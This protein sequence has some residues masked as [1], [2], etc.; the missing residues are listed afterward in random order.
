MA[1]IKRFLGTFGT[2]GFGIL[3]AIIVLEI[4]GRVLH[5]APV[6][7][8]D[9]YQNVREVVGRFPEPYS[10]FWFNR[11]DGERIWVQ[12]NY[13]S[14]RDIDHD[15][16][17]DDTTTRIMF[18]GDSY[19]AGWQVP[20]ND[21]YTGRLR[22]WLSDS[23][24][25]DFINAG[26]HG[27]GTDRE[28]LYYRTEGYRYNS[29]VVVLQVYVG[30]DMIDNGIA[31]IEQRELPDGRHIATQSLTEERPYFTLGDDGELDFTAPRW[32]PS[33]RAER[34]GGIRSFLRQYVFTYALLEQLMQLRSENSDTDNEYAV[35]FDE[36]FPADYYAFAPQSKTDD[37]WQSAWEITTQLIQQLRV[38]V[39]ANGSTLMVLLVDARWQHDLNAFATLRQT[40]D[41]PQDWQP[42]RWGNRFR[43]FLD[44]EDI[45]YIAPIDALLAYRDATGNAIVLQKD[46]HW[47]AQGQCVV[48]VELHNWLIERDVIDD[49]VA[50]RDSLIEC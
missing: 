29:D 50:Q 15:Y 13:R 25:V 16:E 11:E 19:T 41:I 32:L 27:W 45:P 24:N 8:P 35:R 9:S 5:L 46:G 20:L 21:T 10:Y 1:R 14:L 39:E 31:V 43:D 36:L 42:S 17:K 22:D 6:A 4:M 34:I 30:N 47:T 33:T 28:Y 38:E 40:W 18:L 7:L 48:A 44:T 49:T 2:V 23:D 26:L 37:D 12:F 3:I